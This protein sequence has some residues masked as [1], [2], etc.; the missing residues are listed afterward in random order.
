MHSKDMFL[1]ADNREFST[2]ILYTIIMRYAFPNPIHKLR[3]TSFDCTE[4]I[5]I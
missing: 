5:I 1:Y 4:L 2:I 3:K